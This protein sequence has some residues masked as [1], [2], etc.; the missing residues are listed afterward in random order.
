MLSPRILLL[1]ALG[2]GLGGVLRHVTSVLLARW[3]GSSFPYGTLAV[4]LI[5]SGLIAFVVTA[6]SRQLLSDEARIF[7]AVGVM[8]GLTT[9]SSFNDQVLT[10]LKHGQLGTAGGYFLGTV[11]GCLAFGMAGVWAGE[12]W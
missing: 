8:G 2:S 10:A 9:Y 12:R 3:T 1:V 11:L 7:L 6:A 4:N 5:G